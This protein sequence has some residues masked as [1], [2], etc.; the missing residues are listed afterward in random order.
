MAKGRIEA[1]REI[2]RKVDEDPD[3]KERLAA[4]ECVLC[5]KSS[6]IGGAAI[7]PAHCAFCGLEMVHG[8]T[9]VDAMCL[10]C[11]KHAGLCKHCGADIDLKNRRKRD[12][13]EVIEI[14]ETE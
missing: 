1:Y 11:A 7:T 2:L 4:M 8:S 12:L 3:R 13:P 10:S 6:R 5:W 9:N 14:Q